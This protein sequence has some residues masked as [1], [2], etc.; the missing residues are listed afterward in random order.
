MI[1]IAVQGFVAHRP[2]DDLPHAL[3]F[4]EAREVHQHG[5]GGEQLQAFGEGAED[6]QGLGDI[7]LDCRP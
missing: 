1:E 4:V 7:V 3:H 6:R 5:E 2:G